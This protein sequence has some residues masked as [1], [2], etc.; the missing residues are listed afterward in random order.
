MF[1][2]ETVTSSSQN[3]YV[4]DVPRGR[5]GV[6]WATQHDRLR[7]T[8]VLAAQFIEV[9]GRTKA[10][11]VGSLHHYRSLSHNWEP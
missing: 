2:E 8:S 6:L 9:V 1:A 7:Q 3:L 5:L 10:N 4:G 11:Q